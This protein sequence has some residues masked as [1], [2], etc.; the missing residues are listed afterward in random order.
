MPFAALNVLCK[1]PLNSVV[2]DPGGEILR[3]EV[4][5]G[6]TEK[7]LLHIKM[8][9]L[10]NAHTQVDVRVPNEDLTEWVSVQISQN[11]SNATS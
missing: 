11:S 2:Y 4:F 3:Q 7:L 9:S 10:S 8:K 5:T 6:K 1:L